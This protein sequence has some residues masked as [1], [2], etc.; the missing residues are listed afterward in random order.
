MPIADRVV[1]V[2]GARGALGRASAEAF[3]NA[4]ARVAL[5]GRDPE[6]VARIAGDLAIEE[7]RW[8]AAIGD[9]RT[10][11]GARSA[12]AAAIQRFGRIDVVIH[13]VGGFAP[14]SPIVDL[15]H[16]QIRMMIDQHLWTTVNLVQA[17]V[18]SMV[19]RGWGRVL[20]ATSF[21]TATV[22]AR[23]GLYAATK[24][25]Q[26]NLL[27]SLAKEVGPSGVTVNVVALRAI[28]EKHERDTGD[29]PKKAAW[30]TPEEIAA[31]FLF[32][33]SD[34]AATINGARIPLDGRA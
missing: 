28:D 24:G 23:A 27:R 10:G 1:F 30:T 11:E 25:A 33:A 16:D 18:P 14:G 29:D 9:L 20:A 6:G 31:V 17:T 7:S 32:L 2:A 21:T 15:D 34:D 4:G 12:V 8:V 26:E 19:E 5:G 13:G 3:A 22:P